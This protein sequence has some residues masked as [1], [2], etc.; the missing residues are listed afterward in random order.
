MID[1]SPSAKRHPLFAHL[2]CKQAFV[3][4]DWEGQLIEK[5]EGKREGGGEGGRG[6]RER[7]GRNGGRDGGREG[8]MERRGE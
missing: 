6:G 7:G 8:G 5:M 2:H 4:V 3:L 1:Y